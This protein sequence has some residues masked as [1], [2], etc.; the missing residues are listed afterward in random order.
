MEASTEF[1]GANLARKYHPVSGRDDV[2][3]EKLDVDLM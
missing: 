3:K 2:G 1:I